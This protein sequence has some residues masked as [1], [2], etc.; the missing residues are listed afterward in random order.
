VQRAEADLFDANGK[1]TRAQEMFKGSPDLSAATRRS[2]QPATRAR[3]PATTS[4][5]KKWT[6]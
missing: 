5:C 4:H 3:K 1:Y 6:G 2:K